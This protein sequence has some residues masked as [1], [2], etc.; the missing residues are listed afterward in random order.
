MNIKNEKDNN[1]YQSYGEKL[2]YL[3]K[4]SSWYKWSKSHHCCDTT[5]ILADKRF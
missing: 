4:S 5:E 2:K 1:L 3:Q